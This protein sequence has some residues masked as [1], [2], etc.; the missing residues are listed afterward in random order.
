MFTFIDPTLPLLPKRSCQPNVGY[1]L[2]MFEADPDCTE[3]L[4]LNWPLWSGANY[5]SRYAPKQ[6]QLQRITLHKRI[7][8]RG[9]FMYILMCEFAEALAHLPV[10][11]G[12]VDKVRARQC[13]FSSLYSVDHYFWLLFPVCC[14]PKTGSCLFTLTESW[15]DQQKTSFSCFAM[16]SVLEN[17]KHLKS[18]PHFCVAFPIHVHCTMQTRLGFQSHLPAARSDLQSHAAMS[19]SCL[20]AAGPHTPA[21]N[22]FWQISFNSKFFPLNFFCLFIYY[23]FAVFFFFFWHF[24]SQ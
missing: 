7:S 23:F 2:S 9:T 5:I 16:R 15:Q 20:C 18:S 11:L 8:S 17:Y 12:F 4:D 14:L 24:C 13:G 10:A 21:P 1:L 3:Q 19:S 22:S 6:L